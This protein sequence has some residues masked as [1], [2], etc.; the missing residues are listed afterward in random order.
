MA[1]VLRDPR[2]LLVAYNAAQ[3]EIGH[4]GW[5]FEAGLAERMQDLGN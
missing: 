1:P 3:D 2:K 4:G 5:A